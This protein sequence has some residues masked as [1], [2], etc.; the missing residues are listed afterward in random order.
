VIVSGDVVPRRDTDAE[1][2]VAG[3]S[4]KAHIR[5]DAGRVITCP[6][7]PGALPDGVMA[8]VVAVA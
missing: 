1:L 2:Y 7:I 3:L 4:N 6:F 5:A 8:L